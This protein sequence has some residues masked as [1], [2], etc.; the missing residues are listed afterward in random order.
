MVRGRWM[1]AAGGGC[2]HARAYA[3]LGRFLQDPKCLQLQFFV[4]VF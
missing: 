2:P 3:I 4:R 1:Q